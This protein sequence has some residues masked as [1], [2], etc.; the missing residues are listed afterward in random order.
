[1]KLVMLNSLRARSGESVGDYVGH[2][3]KLG[4]VRARNGMDSGGD[5]LNWPHARIVTIAEVYGCWGPKLVYAMSSF[6]FAK[7]IE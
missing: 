4:Q 1:M 7:M 6:P 2:T 5:N 3:C